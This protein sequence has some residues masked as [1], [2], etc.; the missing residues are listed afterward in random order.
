MIRSLRAALAAFVLLSAGSAWAGAPGERLE[1]VVILSRH[2]VRAAMSSPERLEERGPIERPAPHP[3]DRCYFDTG[4]EAQQRRRYRDFVE[5]HFRLLDFRSA[6]G[7]RTPRAVDIQRHQHLPAGN[8]LVHQ[9][10]AI[11]DALHHQ[12]IIT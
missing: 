11:P 2:G 4:I 12:S 3:I 7:T 8:L 5:Q 10:Y 1:K 6:A 9:P